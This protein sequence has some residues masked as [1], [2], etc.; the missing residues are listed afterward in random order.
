MKRIA[1]AT[2]WF[3]AGWFAGSF[4]AFAA[5]LPGVLG[6][7]VAIVS[8]AIVARDPLGWFS[9]RSPMVTSRLMAIRPPAQ[10]PA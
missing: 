8:A 1:A 5:D 2:A 3:F 4:I 10:N 6:P 9:T 7:I